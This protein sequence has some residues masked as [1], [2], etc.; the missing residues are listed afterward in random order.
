MLKEYKILDFTREELGELYSSRTD[1]KVLSVWSP[2][3]VKLLS[4]TSPYTVKNISK[5]TNID[6]PI[7]QS[8]LE[9]QAKALV[10][11]LTLSIDNSLFKGI[12]RTDMVRSKVD[13]LKKLNEVLGLT[14]SFTEE[15]I[16]IENIIEMSYNVKSSA[17][18]IGSRF[19]RRFE[20]TVRLETLNPLGFENFFVDLFKDNLRSIVL[21][22]SSTNGNGKDFDL[23]IFVDELSLDMYNAI[24]D[25]QKEIASA[26]PVGIVLL[27]SLA[28]ESYAECDY[29]SLTISKEGIL[30]FGKP[31]EFPVLSEEEG[32]NKMY[33]KS[34]KEMTNL[35][36]ALNN[37][38]RLESLVK[39]PNFLRETLKL[40]IWIRK[41]LA[42]K[43][44]R[45]YLTKEEFLKKEPIK[46]ADLGKSPTK[47][48]VHNALLD[49]NYR[50]KLAVDKYMN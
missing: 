27:P 1:D 12:M 5:A 29:Q 48:E 8:S 22:G 14:P 37:G 2:S 24:W 18:K 40:E 35:R 34:G 45:R 7:S 38:N 39:S 44:E 19:N 49:A 23:M 20:K 9:E 13:N 4:D 36:G 16:K 46:I 31:L 6:Y 50:V 10:A 11:Y 43:K 26:K 17:L 32:I 42:Q 3:E 41:A 33:Y 47:E 28:L 25:R 30:T 21:Y 15:N